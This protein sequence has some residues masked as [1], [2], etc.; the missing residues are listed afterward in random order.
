MAIDCS[1]IPPWLKVMRG[2]TGLTE[3]PGDKDNPK[4]MGMRDWI[5]C[6]YPDMMRYCESYTHDD[7]PWCGLTAGFCMTVAGVRPPYNPE[8]DTDSFLWAL[9]WADDPG[10]MVID[11]PVLGCVVVM[12][13]EGGG[14]VT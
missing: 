10:F 11:R 5:A 4:I 7:V 2:I 3:E 14:H 12:E 8:V 13:R 9:S 6:T 1:S